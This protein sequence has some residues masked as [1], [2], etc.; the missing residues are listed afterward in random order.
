MLLKDD[1]L[2]KN[3]VLDWNYTTGSNTIKATIAGDEQSNAPM[4][5]I[6]GIEYNSKNGQ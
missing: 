2:I 5:S 6:D 3:A 1:A 4:V